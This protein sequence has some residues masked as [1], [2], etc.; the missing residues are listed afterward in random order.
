MELVSWQEL[1]LA[2]VSLLLV[3]VVQ[4]FWLQLSELLLF[5]SLRLVLA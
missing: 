2:L 4:A 3:W 5:C 1:S